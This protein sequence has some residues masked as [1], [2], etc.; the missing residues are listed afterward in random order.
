MKNE[1]IIRN[2]NIL[3]LSLSLSSL[4]AQDT[5][6]ITL[7]Q[8]IYESGIHSVDALVAKNEFRSSYWEYRTYKAE[9]LPEVILDGTLPYYSKSYNQFQNT[10]GTYTFVGNDYSRLDAAISINQN[11]P[12]T[13]GKLSIGSSLQRLDQLGDHSTTKY[14]A[15]PAAITL[16]QPVFGFNRVKWLQKIEPVKYKEAKARLVSQ[17]ENVTVLAINHYFNLLLGEMNL[18]IAIQNHKNTDRLYTIAEAKRKIGQISENDLLQLKISC[19]KAE[20]YVTEAQSSLKADMFRLRSFLGYSENIVLVPSIPES[21][22]NLQLDY[23]NVLV[24][25]T[26]NSA[27]TQEIRRRQLEAARS[28]SQAKSERRNV[29]LFLS[30]GLS[31]QDSHIPT[32][33]DNLRSNQIVNLGIRI[34]ILDWGKG[35]GRVKMAE[36]NREVVQSKIEKEK[37][38]FNQ[39]IFL[40]VENFNNQSKQL[41]IAVETDRIAQKRYETSI[42]AFILGKIDVLNLN[43]AQ[44]SK[45]EARRKYIEEMYLLW[46]YYYQIRSV[47]LH[48]FINNR[49]LYTDYDGIVK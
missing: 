17:M 32:I 25:A 5:I 16:E 26:E 18:N 7:G 35:K 29:N 27:F 44:S 12:W 23:D 19:L 34:P 15:M 45:D 6:R 24:L 38:D 41:K 30:F 22:E 11:I 37:I 9:L 2:M 42:E 13:G 39:N 33:F 28:I 4:S 48:D 8:A 31:G 21:P 49:N 14:M 40:Q 10:D 36:S 43:D 3:L 1:K 47:T 20:A 46:S